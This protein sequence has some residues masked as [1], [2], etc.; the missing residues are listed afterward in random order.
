MYVPLP[1][2]EI[3]LGEPLPVNVW[4]ARGQL[5][6]RK[7]AIIRDEHHREW[8]RMHAP[9]IRREDHEVWR[10]HYT[11]ALDRALRSNQPLQAIAG[12]A[13][14]M[15]FEPPAAIDEDQ[16]PLTEALADLHAALTLLLHQGEQLQDWSGRF[17]RVDQRLQA[18]LRQHGADDVLFVLVQMLLNLELGYSASHALTCAVVAELTAHHTL[19]WP[20]ATLQSLRRAALSMNV[21]MARLH[22]DL[23]RQEGPLHGEQRRAVLAH[24]ERGEGL[25]RRLGVSDPLWLALVRD[26]HEVS[27]GGGYPRGVADPSREAQLLRLAD[28]YVA[29]LSPRV[30]RPGLPPPRAARDVALDASGLP[31]PLGTALVK[32]VGLYV[33]GS[34][35]ELAS[36]ELGVVARRGRRANTPLVFALI[37]RDGLPRGEPPLRDTEQPAWAVRGSVAPQQVKVRV[38]P[39]RLLARL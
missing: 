39:D 17:V 15:A 5:L 14:P 23:A 27:G 30:H 37:G 34:Y 32:T 6:L 7:G 16:R 31:T 10:F 2:D 21:G 26:H 11:A 35:V 9:M 3:T 25:L 13:R 33:P 24:P 22:D 38:N 20:E 29:R 36:G 8:L 12:V 4:D 18:L 1:I 28:V 19:R